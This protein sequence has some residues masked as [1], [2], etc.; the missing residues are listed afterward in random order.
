MIRSMVKIR[1][2]IEISLNILKISSH[3]DNINELFK[4]L[5]LTVFELHQN[6]LNF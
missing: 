2:N 4:C 1:I 3:I 5:Q 6:N